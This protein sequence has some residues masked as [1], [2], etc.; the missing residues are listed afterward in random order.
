MKKDDGFN[1]MEKWMEALFSPKSVA[2][3]G[4]SRDGK[5]AGYGVLKSLVTGCVFM[6]KACSPFRGK[7]YAIN[8]NAKSIL[9]KKCF[10]SIAEIPESV[11]LAIICVPA[12][13]VPQVMK[14]CAENGVKTAI[15][16]SAGFAELG[17]E[18]RKL[19]E[20]IA[21]IAKAAKM[22]VLGPNSL[23]IIRPE[24]NLNASFALSTPEAGEIA[25]ISQSGAIA[26][27][28]VDWALE[29]RY[30]FSTIVSLGNSS[31]LDVSDFLKYCLQDNE[32]KAIAM[33]LEWIKDGKKFMNIAKKV[34]KKKPIVLLKG[35]RTEKGNAAAISHTGNIAGSFSVYE[36]AMKQCGVFMV[37][38]IEDLFDLTKAL[39]EQPRSN[40]KR[41][42]II[43]NGG[44]VGVLT[45]DY[46]AQMG[47]EVVKLN[48]TTL[49]KLEKT[50]KM[51]KAYSRSNP[52][53]LVGDALP[54][55]YETAINILL[56]EKYI[57]GL[58]VIQTLQTMT[59]SEEDAKVIINAHRRFPKKP[60]V[61]VFMG[62]KYTAKGVALLRKNNI[63]DY[64]DPLKAVKVM[65]ALCGVV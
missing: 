46:C 50:G 26:D 23:G 33:Y 56:S 55:R 1:F 57:D 18:G 40:G 13:I 42:G 49:N 39:S 19:Q 8:P 41:I 29:A 43:T 25:F 51:H 37:E 63:S 3:I 14:D 52:V 28:V 32:T 4:A 64:N 54:E 7:I 61:C 9:G 47:L 59:Q 12:K 31:D 30:S 22:R 2:V 45:A 65:K 60:I 62:G 44:G 21:R 16:I 24:K 35:G 48:E 17:E 11:D 38:S 36:A 6:A 5:S 58:I 34:A 27:S 15:I 10:G 53:D 20:E